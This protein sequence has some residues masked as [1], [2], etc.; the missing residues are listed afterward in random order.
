MSSAPHVALLDTPRT[1]EAWAT[2]SKTEVYRVMG[3]M[4]RELAAARISISEAHAA[5][6]S[7]ISDIMQKLSD[8]AKVHAN[9]LRGI[10]ARI[11]PLQAAHIEG[12]GAVERYQAQEAALE[13]A[14]EMR[15]AGAALYEVVRDLAH[16]LMPT[17]KRHVEVVA[18]WDAAVA[19]NPEAGAVA[20]CAR[21]VAKDGGSVTRH[22]DSGPDNDLTGLIPLARLGLAVLSEA[23]VHGVGDVDGGWLQDKAESLGVLVKVKVTEFCSETCNCAEYYDS[24]ELPVECLRISEEAIAARSVLRVCTP[25]E[26]DR[27]THMRCDKECRAAPCSYTA[28]KEK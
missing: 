20:S 8:P 19:K 14:V 17:G 27:C 13:Y 3:D 22:P 21:G 28:H 23:R 11:T 9:M 6:A 7:E 4:E 15:E 18:M 16:G 5:H 2:G 24:A 12:N 26:R 1:D 10:I 25:E